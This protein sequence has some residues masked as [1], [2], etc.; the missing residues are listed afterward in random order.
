MY[1]QYTTKI[2]LSQS[3]MRILDILIFEGKK[4]RREI[5]KK[6]ED[7]EKTNSEKA[8]K[9]LGPDYSTI[10][11]AVRRL[12]KKGLVELVEEKKLKR[13]KI[14]DIT[15]NGCAEL[16]ITKSKNQ[17]LFDY[18]NSHTAKAIREKWL[19]RFPEWVKNSQE[20]SFLKAFNISPSFVEFLLNF[21]EMLQP[22]IIKNINLF[23]EMFTNL[24]DSHAVVISDID[25]ASKFYITPSTINISNTGL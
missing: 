5:H 15:L 16:Y 1:C 3:A 6:I 9:E 8:P 22:N 17:H 25:A 7:E 13:E 19:E 11:R 18:H 20:S 10:L 21:N 2:I 24:K 12:E 14:Y 23:R 4:S